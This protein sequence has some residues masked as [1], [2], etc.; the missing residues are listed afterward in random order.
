MAQDL[1]IRGLMAWR[2]MEGERVGLVAQMRFLE[3]FGRIGHCG[4]RG[5]VGLVA[6]MRFLEVFGRIGH[7]GLRG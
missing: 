5:R 2:S 7:C 6:Q 3:V 4:L 1:R